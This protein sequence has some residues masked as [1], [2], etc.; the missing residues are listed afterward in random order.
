MKD[1]GIDFYSTGKRP[2]DFGVINQYGLSKK[3]RAN[4]RHVPPCVTDDI[5]VS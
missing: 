1:T 2:E 3:V 4:V 5:G